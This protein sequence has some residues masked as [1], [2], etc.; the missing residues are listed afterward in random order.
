MSIK[1]IIEAWK[2]PVKRAKLTPEELAQLP[3]NPA[4]DVELDPAELES[5]AGGQRPRPPTGTTT[6]GT[7]TCDLC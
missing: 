7:S 4:G 6:C 5:I 2:D 3:K 1:D